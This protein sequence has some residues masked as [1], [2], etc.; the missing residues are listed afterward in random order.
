MQVCNVGEKVPDHCSSDPDSVLER[1]QVSPWTD[2]TAVSSLCVLV[3]AGI[4]PAGAPFFRAPQLHRVS[5]I[6]TCPR[7]QRCSAVSRART[8]PSS[9]SSDA[10]AVRL[11][12]SPSW[13]SAP[14]WQGRR[15]DVGGR[16]LGAG[17]TPLGR[18]GRCCCSASS[19]GSAS[20][21]SGSL[22]PLLSGHSS[23]GSLSL[24]SCLALRGWCPGHPMQPG[25]AHSSESDHS[26]AS[27]SAA[28]WPRARLFCMTGVSSVASSKYTTSSLAL[29]ESIRPFTGSVHS[30]PSL[31]LPA[32]HSLVVDSPVLSLAG[33]QVVSHD[34]S[35]A[36]HVTL[37]PLCCHSVE[38]AVSVWLRSFSSEFQP[39]HLSLDSPREVTVVLRRVLRAMLLCVVLRQVDECCRLVCRLPVLG[40]SA[41]LARPDDLEVV[42]R[43]FARAV[44]PCHL[45]VVERAFMVCPQ[46]V[47]ASRVRSPHPDVSTQRPCCCTH[48]CLVSPDC[49][50]HTCQIGVH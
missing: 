50:F 42:Q 8:T 16:C 6:P 45:S 28:R 22:S 19:S 46:S 40:C 15:P 24:C 13:S 14:R 39:L 5:L 43:P 17:L 7:S 26:E 11:P 23:A 12:S 32:A 41:S 27:G 44:D 3:R 1:A 36:V 37:P 25:S 2:V 31:S 35:P 30:A 34:C 47:F 10:S 4:R 49:S 33:H 48:H 20:A 38:H 18:V 9:S 21:G 29:L